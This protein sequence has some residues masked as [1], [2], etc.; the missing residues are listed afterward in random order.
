MELEGVAAWWHGP[1]RSVELAVFRPLG[2]TADS[3]V[4][5]VVHGLMGQGGGNL[6][7][8]AASEAFLQ[9]VGIAEPASERTLVEKLARAFDAV[10]SELSRLSGERQGTLAATFLAAYFSRGHVA[11]AQAGDARAWLLRGGVMTQVVEAHTLWR[12]AER[13]GMPI[14]ETELPN[15]ATR[16]LGFPSEGPDFSLLPVHEGDVFLLHTG[17]F[18]S[19]PI[20][21]IERCLSR[22]QS[23]ERIAAELLAA[24]SPTPVDERSLVVVR[25]HRSGARVR[26]EQEASTA[27]ETGMANAEFQRER[28]LQALVQLC[29]TGARTDD[30][31]C[32]AL[33]LLQIRGVKDLWVPRPGADALD[34]TISSDDRRVSEAT[35]LFTRALLAAFSILP[36]DANVRG[37][38]HETWWSLFQEATDRA[39]GRQADHEFLWVTL[40]IF[41]FAGFGGP[42][43]TKSAGLRALFPDKEQRLLLLELA[44]CRRCPDVEEFEHGLLAAEIEQLTSTDDEVREVLERVWPGNRAWEAHLRGART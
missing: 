36:M 34:V 10:E 11:F 31:P 4:A 42:S 18:S 20:S 14:D 35:G 3:A 41:R 38:W 13:S 17:G 15:V 30:V 43:A 6:P 27:T 16:A 22:P 21:T 9:S 12:E 28:F 32:H 29:G 39:L 33:R 8:L 37:E 44:L 26:P 23:V 7:A 24:A 25:I 2:S 1:L 40:A 5:F 19:V